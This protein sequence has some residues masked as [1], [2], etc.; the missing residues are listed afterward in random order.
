MRRA[1]VYVVMSVDG[2][3]ERMLVDTGGI[4]STLSETVAKTLNLSLR[5]F[6]P[7]AVYFTQYGGLRLNTY[8]VA[9]RITL[10]QMH[11]GSTDFVLMPTGICRRGSTARSRRIS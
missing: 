10:G 9:D 3:D 1:E 7:E 2:H 6:E 5:H 11:S 4:A 8:S